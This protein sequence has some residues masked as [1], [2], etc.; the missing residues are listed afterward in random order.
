MDLSGFQINSE[1]FLTGPNYNYLFLFRIV[2]VQTI[3]A[4]TSLCILIFDATFEAVLVQNKSSVHSVK[5]EQKMAAHKPGMRNIDNHSKNR[6]LNKILIE[7]CTIN[8]TNR[9]KI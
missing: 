8:A 1:S 3:C 6:K 9:V 4:Q 7:T 5:L 2:Y